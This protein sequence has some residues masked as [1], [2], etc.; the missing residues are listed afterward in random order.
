MQGTLH[1]PS[2]NGL[3]LCNGR[4]ANEEARLMEAA[5]QD[6]EHDR[7]VTEMHHLPNMLHHQ[8]TRASA[9]GRRIAEV[10]KRDMTELG[11]IEAALMG[12]G[13]VK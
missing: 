8:A 13:R 1:S 2:S 9:V 7:A 10:D 11:A 5:I 3:D 4:A 12:L 6:F